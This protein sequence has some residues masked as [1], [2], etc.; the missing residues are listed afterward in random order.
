[1]SKRALLCGMLA[2]FL[3]VAVYGREGFGFT[4]K[5]VDMTKTV[6]P[7]IN[8]SGTRVSVAV[9]TEHTRVSGKATRAGDGGQLDA[10]C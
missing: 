5:S 6:P 8:V 4:K 2:L 7:A 9:D 3:S 1:M 10:G